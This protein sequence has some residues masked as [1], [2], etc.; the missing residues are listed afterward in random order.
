MGLVRLVQRKAQSIGLGTDAFCAQTGVRPDELADVHGRMDAARYARV[1]RVLCHYLLDCHGHRPQPPSLPALFDDLPRLT[2]LWCN[3]PSLGA[4][5]MHYVQFRR[6]LGE[7]DALDCQVQGDAMALTY[8]PDVPGAAGLCSAIGNFALLVGCIQH[9]QADSSHAER[10]GLGIELQLAAMPGPATAR[11]QDALGVVFQLGNVHRL[12]VHGQELWSP[13]Q[14]F[15]PVLHDLSRR[16]L[17][18]DLQQLDSVPRFATQVQAAIEQVWAD[19]LYLSS[20]ALAGL[21]SAVADRLGLS[22]WTLRRRLEDEGQSFQ[23]LVDALRA[24]RAQRLLGEPG[25]SMLDISQRLGFA[26]Q[27]S[28]NRFYRKHFDR[29]PMQARQDM[30]AA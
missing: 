4:A 1:H 5:L 22:R 7:P 19:S 25:P 26:T 2:A 16:A 3:S 30:Q 14:H 27:S 12:V 23:A 24:R 6:V 28:F 9:Y 21:L 17:E 20:P 15:N 8:R 10:R 13:A 18:R 11:W 29:T